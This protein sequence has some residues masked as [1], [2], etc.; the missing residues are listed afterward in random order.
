MTHADGLSAAF[1]QATAFVQPA[2]VSI[3]SE[4]EFRISSG[5]R[6]ELPQVPEEFRHFFG[7]E[8]ERFFQ[9]P[10]PEGRAVQRGFGS[11]VI[12]SRDG[13]ILLHRNQ[14]ALSL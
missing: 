8:F 7:D 11:G 4:K 13:Y 5:S 9:R 1:R 3:T 12:V 14:S 10:S 6:G 2:V